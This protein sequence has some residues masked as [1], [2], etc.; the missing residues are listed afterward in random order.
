MKNEIKI[1]ISEQDIVEFL[2]QH[3]NMAAAILGESYRSAGIEV[4]L[5][6]DEVEVKCRTYTSDL[7]GAYGKT[8]AECHT[9]MVALRREAL[10]KRL[11]EVNAEAD[12]IRSLIEKEAA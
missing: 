5:S 11:S 7:S 6:G 4:N 12:R 3:A 8:F 9:N 10:E 1:Q 2:T